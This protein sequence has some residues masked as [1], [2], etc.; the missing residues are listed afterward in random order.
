M[1]E[2]WPLWTDKK[3]VENDQL[4]MTKEMYDKIKQVHNLK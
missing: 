2:F 4:V 3:K 1:E